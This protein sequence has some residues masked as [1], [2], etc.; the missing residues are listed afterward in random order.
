V[1]RRGMR[2][3]MRIV[4]ESQKFDEWTAST[5]LSALWINILTAAT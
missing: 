1:P 3:V 4:A 5:I 2:K